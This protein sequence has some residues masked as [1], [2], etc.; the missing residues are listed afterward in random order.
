MTQH[1]ATLVEQ[2]AAA[3]QSLDEQAIDMTRLIARFKVGEALTA[4]NV[5]E[6]EAQ[7]A[8]AGTPRRL[9]CS[10]A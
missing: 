9:S 6:S 1:N 7:T 3:S 8:D 4:G 10:A 2:V 5:W